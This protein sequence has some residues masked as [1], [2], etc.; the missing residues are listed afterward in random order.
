MAEFHQSPAYKVYARF[1]DNLSQELKETALCLEDQ[2]VTIDIAGQKHVHVVTIKE[3]LFELKG[4][5]NQ[6]I[7]ERSFFK[8]AVARYE[9]LKKQKSLKRKQQRTKRV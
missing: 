8:N 6:M 2:H 1:Q 7:A 9:K 4:R 5:Q 3:Q